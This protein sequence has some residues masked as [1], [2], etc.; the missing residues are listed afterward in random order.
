MGVKLELMGNR[1]GV[2]RVVH[3]TS[4]E[5]QVFDIDNRPVRTFG[6]VREMELKSEKYFGMPI[7]AIKIRLHCRNEKPYN[8][9]WLFR[10]QENY[11]F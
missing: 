6:S 4:K 5:V 11:V 1:C 8:G 3:T 7:T 10:M 9:K 2:A